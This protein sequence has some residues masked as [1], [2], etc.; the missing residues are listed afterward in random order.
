MKAINLLADALK[1]FSN[2]ELKL[3]E[4][5]LNSPYLKKRKFHNPAVHALYK[6]LFRPQKDRSKLSVINFS[7]KIADE[8]LEYLYDF[9][10]FERLKRRK[11]EFYIQMAKELDEKNQI[12]LLARRYKAK[13]FKYLDTEDEESNYYHSY[14]LI[15][16]LNKHLEKTSWAVEKWHYELE[17]YLLNEYY[18]FEAEDIKKRLQLNMQKK[19][20]T[21]FNLDLNPSAWHTA[22]A[23]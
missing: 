11:V 12:E 17:L 21:Y 3:F 15:K 5:F 2:N 1:S 8:L 23:E 6:Q 10:T 20:C 4:K 9:I 22:K 7:N 14:E 13:L 16:T 19:G 18:N